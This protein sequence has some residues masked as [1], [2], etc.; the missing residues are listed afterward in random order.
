MISYYNAPGLLAI[1][2]L[3]FNSCSLNK[4]NTLKSI[5]LYLIILNGILRFFMG[6]AIQRTYNQHYWV[7]KTIERKSGVIDKKENM[8][9][10]GGISRLGFGTIFLLK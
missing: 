9:A 8:P 5:I 3:R 4:S 1:N 6:R 10:L 2:E 7:Q